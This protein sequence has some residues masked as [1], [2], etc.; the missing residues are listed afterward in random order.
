MFLRSRI[1]VSGR[2]RPRSRQE[3]KRDGHANSQKNQGKGRTQYG[4]HEKERSTMNIAE[5]SDKVKVGP[6]DAI[7]NRNP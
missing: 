3:K 1:T 5:N 2:Q 6:L 4:R 7:G